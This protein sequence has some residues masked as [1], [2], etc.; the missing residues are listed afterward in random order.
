G[1]KFLKRLIIFRQHNVYGKDRGEEH[2]IPEFIKKIKNI[3]S[4]KG[5][6]HI[7]GTGNEIR[8]WIIIEVQKNMFR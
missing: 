8:S 1:K 4:K 7:K 5:K 3:K 6:I 2:V